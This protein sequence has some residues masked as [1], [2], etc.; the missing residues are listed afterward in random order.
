MATDPSSQFPPF[1][2]INLPRTEPIVLDTAIGRKLGNHIASIRLHPH[3]YSLIHNLI[4]GSPKP[5]NALQS[6]CRRELRGLDIHLDDGGEHSLTHG[7][8]NNFPIIMPA[9][10]NSI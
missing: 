4:P 7:T 8:Q 10:G 2:S 3:T 9:P 6:A 1:L 5:T